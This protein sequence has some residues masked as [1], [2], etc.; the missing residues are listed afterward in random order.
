LDRIHDVRKSERTFQVNRSL[1]TIIFGDG[2]QNVNEEEIRQ[3]SLFQQWLARITSSG[4]I[5][6]DSVHIHAAYKWGKPTEIKM[7]QLE[8]VARDLEGR[9]LGGITTLRGDTVDVLTVVNSWGRDYVVLV[10]QLRVPGAQ[11]VVSNP[12]GMVDDGESKAK[13]SDREREEELGIKL[14]PGKMIDLA[15]AVHGHQLPYLVSSGTSDERSNMMVTI[16]DAPPSLL[17]RLEGKV[18]GLLEEGEQTRVIVVPFK[19]VFG[20][21]ESAGSA[22]AKL[23]LSLHLYGVYRR[24][25]S[26]RL[27]RW[28]TVLNWR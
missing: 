2:V 16:S 19:Q 20:V 12:S 25:F 8:V 27:R 28:L 18:G 14:P 5:V 21:L 1:P 7:I 4:E 15:E 24:K 3:S 23:V 11:R 26:V 17:K 10:S 6:L 13:A 22:P 9:K